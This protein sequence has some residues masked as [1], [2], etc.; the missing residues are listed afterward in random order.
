MLSVLLEYVPAAAAP[1]PRPLTLTLT[2]SLT[3]TLTTTHLQQQLPALGRRL[4]HPKVA[5]RRPARR[6]IVLVQHAAAEVREGLLPV[7]G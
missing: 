2:L 6:A 4:D 7:H 5:S 3:L 1:R